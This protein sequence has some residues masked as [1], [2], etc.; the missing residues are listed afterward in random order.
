MPPTTM[1]YRH[2]SCEPKGL[3]A[4]GPYVCPT[5]SENLGIWARKQIMRERATGEW[6]ILWECRHGLRSHRHTHKISHKIKGGMPGTILSPWG[7]SGMYS[8]W[9]QV[10]VGLRRFPGCPPS[11]CSSWVYASLEALSDICLRFH[12]S[13][14][15][16][17]AAQHN[18]SRSTSQ[19]QTFG[20]R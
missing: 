8:P 16:L 3:A 1:Y 17:E 10:P 4:V 2:I 5:D 14:I 18:H 13:S 9:G 11:F 19:H 7:Q 20:Y 12:S 6:I 15:T